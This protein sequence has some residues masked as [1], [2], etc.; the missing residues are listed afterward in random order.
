MLPVVDVLF[1]SYVG[2]QVGRI[3]AST[4]Q[5]VQ[6]LAV[7]NSFATAS[8]TM[9]MSFRKLGAGHCWQTELT[10]DRLTQ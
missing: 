9:M 10:L 3:G 5:F 7:S 8:A 2:F 6:Q 4:D 1:E